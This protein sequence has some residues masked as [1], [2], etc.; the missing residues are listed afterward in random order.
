V[1]DEEVCGRSRTVEDELRE[2]L[3]ECQEL[4]ARTEELLSKS[5]Q[6]NEPLNRK[7]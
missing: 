5:Q 1:S 3:R 4:L 7:R 6:D 2:A